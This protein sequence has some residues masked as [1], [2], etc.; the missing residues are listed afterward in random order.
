MSSSELN[1]LFIVLQD[2]HHNKQCWVLLV[3]ELRVG[4][5]IAKLHKKRR[6]PT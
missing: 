1:V 3:V 2:Y 5:L 6:V 4:H